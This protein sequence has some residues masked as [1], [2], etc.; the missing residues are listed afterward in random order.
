MQC[1]EYRNDQNT[2]RNYRFIIKIKISLLKIK[3]YAMQE[4]YDK[5]YKFV[6][7]IKIQNALSMK[8]K[9]NY[10]ISKNLIA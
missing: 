6:P 10:V 2:I 4:R 3:H 1:V 8:T 5:V 7:T 9:L